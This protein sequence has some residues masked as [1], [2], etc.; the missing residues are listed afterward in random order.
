MFEFEVKNF[1]SLNYVYIPKK[2]SDQNI[3]IWGHLLV[4]DSFKSVSVNAHK[5]FDSNPSSH[6]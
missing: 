4:L 1:G 6:P 3:S 2:I 5:K